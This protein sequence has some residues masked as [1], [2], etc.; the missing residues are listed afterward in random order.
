MGPLVAERL[1]DHK[2]TL[3]SRNAFLA[4]APA[5]VTEVFGWV[6]QGYLDRFPH[7]SIRDW[8]GGDMTDIV[9]CDFL[10]WQEETLPPADVV[11]NLV[12]GYTQQQEM[13]TKRLIRESLRLNPQALQVAVS[14]REEDIK[15]LSPGAYSIKLDRLK[16]CEDMVTK[17]CL[18][19][20]CLR[21]E[22]YDVE[23]S[24]QSIIDAILSVTH[25]T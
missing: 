10:G 20:K 5:R 9:G 18:N 22:S 12:G 25:Q 7:V 11:V 24:V 8:D 21:L 2:V 23:N 16:R 13:A 4:S 3:L 19:A 1:T 6:G 17:N 14:P 15:T